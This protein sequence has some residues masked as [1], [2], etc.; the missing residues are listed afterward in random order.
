MVTG[1]LSGVVT[2][3]ISGDPIADAGIEI[4]GSVTA[5]EGSTSA[6][7]QYQFADL[8]AG[9]YEIFVFAGGY[10]PLD[11]NITIAEGSNT[12][13]FQL[14]PLAGNSSL[15]GTVV[16]AQS[17]GAIVGANVTISG[18]A[19]RQALTSI[20]GRFQ[21][22]DIPLGD[23]DLAITADGYIDFQQF[24]TVGTE[25]VDLSFAISQ[26]LG[27]ALYRITLSW[28][29]LPFD[30]DA[31]LWAKGNVISWQNPGSED[32]EPF[33]FLDLDDRDGNGPETI[34]IF[35][36][37]TAATFA[38]H[39]WSGEFDDGIDINQSGAHVNVYRDDAL[40]NS[41]DVPRVGDGLWWHVFDIDANGN[42]ITRNV[43]LD[44]P[45]VPTTTGAPQIPARKDMPKP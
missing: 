10:A 21:F 8:P 39:N 18:P 35:D 30:L 13:N 17:G 1:N 14:T 24:V 25:P 20:D 26:Q 28:G 19:Q 38:V 4:S 9:D 37:S 6:L 36:L 31:Y 29:S 40:V 34:T 45:P 42:I 15:S 32:S 27:N 41:Y 33:I 44:G 43:I 12:R 3:A 11:D 22:Q 16:D 2:D 5:R 7:G 23:Y